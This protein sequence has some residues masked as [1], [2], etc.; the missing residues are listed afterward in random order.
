M[1]KKLEDMNDNEIKEELKSIR[2][3]IQVLGEKLYR[4]R[5]WCDRLIRECWSR[6]IFQRK[7]ASIDPDN[8]EVS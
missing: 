5:S 3:E 1:S 8:G 2:F 7:N 6:G 4:K